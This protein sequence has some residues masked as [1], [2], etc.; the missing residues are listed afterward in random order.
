MSR[1][2]RNAQSESPFGLG[3]GGGPSLGA[4]GLGLGAGAGGLGAG[5]EAPPD[6]GPE[7]P[8]E[9][10][11]IDRLV[12]A[13]R[14][15]SGV[16][17][18][19]YK[20]SALGRKLRELA[21]ARGAPSLGAYAAR[22]ERDAGAAAELSLA[23]LNK[24]TA[25]FRD[26]ATFD[27]LREAALPELVARRLDEGATVL[28]AWV[29]ACS[30]GEEAYSI[31]MCLLDE[32][33]RQGAPL[34]ASVVASDVDAAALARAEAGRLD[35]GGAAPLPAPFAARWLLPAAGGRRFAPALR[36]RVRF[37]RHDVVSSAL[38]APAEAA[39][40]SFDLVSCRN[41]LIY[42]APAAQERVLL[43]LL[44]ACAPGALL[45]LGEAE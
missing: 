18:A 6:S 44:K 17:F 45:L 30:T 38:P 35:E 7:A 26:G 25:M 20:R 14:R 41:L 5:D 8:L 43:R 36:E 2:A 42:L 3:A 10:E 13:V 9:G 27:L 11:A 23:L 16:D 4:G 1:A 15:A 40:A 39:F 21:A 22:L 12:V 33:E 31:A 24:T 28:R 19:H 29:P 37:A 34:E 32:V